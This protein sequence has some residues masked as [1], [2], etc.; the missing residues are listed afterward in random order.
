M[1]TLRMPGGQYRGCTLQVI[2]PAYLQWILRHW[3]LSP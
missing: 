1:N 2:P 3:P